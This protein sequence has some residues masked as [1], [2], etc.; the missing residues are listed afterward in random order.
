MK[1]DIII[2]GLT[3]L[4]GGGKDYIGD[5][6]SKEYHFF[7]ISPGDIIR[8]KLA[9]MRSGKINREQQQK[10]QSILRKK[11]GE[12]YVMELCL[13]RIKKEKADKAVISGI[14]FPNDIKFFK[15]QK[16]IK[17]FNIFIYAPIKVRFQRTLDRKRADVP[18]SYKDFIK[19]DKR[20]KE[21]FHLDM[22]EKLSD[23]KLKNGENNSRELYKKIEILMK[24]VI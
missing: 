10:L 2:I 4:P 6:I 19:D 17:F 9:K 7:K 23:F 12:N 24:K 15:K 22:T 3:A 16:G 11:Y 8:E 18:P 21:I 14:R 1:N 5:F 20:E 13:K